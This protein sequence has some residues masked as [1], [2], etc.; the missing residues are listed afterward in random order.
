MYNVSGSD[1]ASHLISCCAQV[2][3]RTLK[4]FWKFGMS[5][6]IWDRWQHCTV[7]CCFSPLDISAENES[8]TF[9]HLMYVS[10]SLDTLHT[11]NPGWSI[12]GWHFKQMWSGIFTH[13]LIV[14]FHIWN[15]L[16]PP[17][18]TYL[19]YTVPWF[20]E[21]NQYRFMISILILELWG[22]FEMLCSLWREDIWNFQSLMYT[23]LKKM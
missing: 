23:V 13:V 10:T 16:L 7:E 6:I 15:G 11:Y 9:W 1:L 19:H 3:F 18:I 22:T 14:N 8:V 2:C 21:G 20:I 5:R 12:D 17:V 4:I